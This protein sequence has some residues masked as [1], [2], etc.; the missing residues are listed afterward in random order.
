MRTRAQRD[1]ALELWRLD[2]CDRVLMRRRPDLYPDISAVPLRPR[3]T[4]RRVVRHLQ[5]LYWV[6]GIAKVKTRLCHGKVAN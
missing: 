1:V 6:A 5:T 3:L 2:M 4:I